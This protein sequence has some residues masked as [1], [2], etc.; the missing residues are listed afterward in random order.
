[1]IE[2]L[3]QQ[4]LRKD[5]VRGGKVEKAEKAEKAEKPVAKSTAKKEKK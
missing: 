2:G 4:T 3:K 1:M 5:W